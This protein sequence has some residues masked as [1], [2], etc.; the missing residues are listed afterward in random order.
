M[1]GAVRSQP[2]RHRGEPQPDN[3]RGAP[4]RTLGGVSGAS[5]RVLQVACARP[6]SATAE[7]VAGHATSAEP[8]APAGSFQQCVISKE[9]GG[10]AQVMNGSG[11]Y[12]LYQF[13]YSSWA[14]AGGSP[15][16]FGNASAA[17]QTA[18]V[19]RSLRPERDIAVG[20][21]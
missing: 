1:A 16:D 2:G 14:A 4:A 9:S 20:A 8:A 10:D 5:G 18:G 15:A 13:S 17:E 6:V 3:R 7:P 19:R 11:H 12:G 21:V